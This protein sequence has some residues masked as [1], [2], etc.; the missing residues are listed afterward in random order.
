MYIH[1]LYKAS[2]DSTVHNSIN[3][4][5]SFSPIG[6]PVSTVNVVTIIIAGIPLSAAT[7]TL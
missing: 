1:D 7:V 4:V 6:L 5:R 3:Y 2:N